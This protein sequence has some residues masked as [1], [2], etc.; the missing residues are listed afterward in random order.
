MAL[1]NNGIMP[2]REYL[3]KTLFVPTYQR[4]YSWDETEL[5]DFWADLEGT[6]TDTDIH[7]FGQIVIHN[8]E[9]K[10]LFIIDGQQRT[11]TSVIFL[12]A[13]QKIYSENCIIKDTEDARAIASEIASLIGR[14]TRKSNDLHLVLGNDDM[15]YFISNIQTGYPDPSKKEK[16]K[17]QERMRKAFIYFEE[18]LNKKIEGINDEDE[19]LDALESIYT[20]FKDNFRVLYMEATKLNE[21]FIIF[22][23][24]NARGKD[25][26]TADLLKNYIF[27]KVNDVKDA[28][29]KWSEMLNT[30]DGIDPTKFI[31][32]LWNSANDFSREKELYKRI[33]KTVNTPKKSKEFLDDVATYALV[34]HDLSNPTDCSYFSDNSL[35]ESL[36]ALKN[37]KA[38][39]FYPIVLALCA[40]GNYDDNTIA[41]IIQTIE[42]Y[43][44]RNISIGGKVANS[45]EV[46][47]AKIAKDISDQVLFEKQDIQDQI[48]EKMITDDEFESL[49]TIWKGSNSAVD[50][51]IV[52]YVLRKTHD[53][54]S[55]T[56]EVVIDNNKVHIEHIM[57]QDGTL[58]L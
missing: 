11:I 13:L 6:I 14:K 44:F 37:L 31:R 12:R 9:D 36:I 18:K 34:Y 51:Y 24:L 3:S 46:F 4:E 48:R 40:Q 25:L 32:H 23:T 7:F 47:F 15:D 54:L 50:K 27:S 39:S 38:S 8:E 16:K 49:F 10:K 41:D 43:F 45:T 58:L 55:A 53:R 56:S 35:K 17:S 57:P 26:E 52:R 2:I 19:M 42:T 1:Q 5:D 29:K 22:E 21:A 28:E 33:V 20:T 30:L